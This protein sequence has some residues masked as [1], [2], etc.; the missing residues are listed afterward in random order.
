M[1][2]PTLDSPSTT[3]TPVSSPDTLASELGEGQLSLED[4]QQLAKTVQHC[5]KSLVEGTWVEVPDVKTGPKFI[6]SSFES[7]KAYLSSSV[8]AI[9]PRG[10]GIPSRIS[11]RCDTDTPL[12]SRHHKGDDM[13][14]CHGCHMPM[15]DGD[16][17]G[18]APGKNVCTFQHSALCRGGIPEN[19]GWRGCPENYV[20]MAHVPTSG[21]E[22]TM[23]TVDFQQPSNFPSH[24]TPVLP[25]GQQGEA[26][27]PPQGQ[28]AVSQPLQGTGLGRAPV[29]HSLQGTG[30]GQLFAAPESLEQRDGQFVQSNIGGYQSSTQENTASLPPQQPQNS[31]ERERLPGMV[32]FH[33]EM[34][35]PLHPIRSHAHLT[36]NGQIDAFRANNQ[37]LENLDRPQ[38][39]TNIT[40]LRADPGLRSD[41][42]EHIVGF[43]E[44]IPS[45]SSAPVPVIN[46]APRSGVTDA[47]QG[48]AY[49][50]TAA[51]LHQVTG[52]GIRITSGS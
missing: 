32:N 24:S 17:N 36:M 21:F 19:D 16:H 22:R 47:Q 10:R 46:P 31:Y 49:S 2:L 18:S 35:P 27:A 5:S 29:L 34:Q 40:H 8:R 39:S 42:E 48:G 12:T 38:G 13:H 6:P 26:S 30:P 20:Y 37:V 11:R 50:Y 51:Q 45:L 3:V 23:D 9:P 1:E 44:R 33:T 7:A 25:P 28:P 15:G 52:D 14:V 41:V 4:C 43:R